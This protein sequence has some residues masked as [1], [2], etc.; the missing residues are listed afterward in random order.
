MIYDLSHTF[1]FLLWFCH[2]LSK[3]EIVRTYVINL[4]NI[5]QI[6]IG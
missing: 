5:C 2:G 4:R 3:G 6:R 1:I